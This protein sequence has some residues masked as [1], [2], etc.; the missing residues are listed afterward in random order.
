[1]TMPPFRAEQVGSLLRPAELREARAAAKAGA[2]SRRRAPSGGGPLDPRRRGQAGVARPSRRHRRRIPAR[3]LA[4]RLSPPARGRGPGAG[5]GPEVPG[6]GRAAD[7]G[8][9]RRDSLRG[10]D[11]GGA[12]PLPGVGDDGR[13]QAHHPGARHAAPARRARRDLARALSGPGAVLERRRPRVPRGDRAP[14][15]GGMRVSAARRRRASPTSA[16]PRCATGSGPAATIPRRCPGPMRT[17]STARSPAARPAW[18]WPCT[19]AAATSAARGWPRCPTRKPS[20]RPCSR[21]TSTPIFM[22]WDSER[23]GGFAPLRRLPRGKTGCARPRHHQVGR[24]RVEGVAEAAHRRSGAVRAAGAPG[25]VTAVR[26]REHPPR[27]H[28][29]RGRAVAQARARG[30]G[31]ARGLG[32]RL[33]GSRGKGKQ[34]GDREQA[35]LRAPASRPG[36]DHGRPRSSIWASAGSVRTALDRGC[37]DIMRPQVAVRSAM[38]RPR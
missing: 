8:G 12:L 35:E 14:R 4:P 28:A 27:Q 10:A 34:R 38:R 3:F 9:R 26:L 16:I 33:S 5:H 7:A 17:R 29:H 37:S 13:A 2:I 32:R 30:R 25:P 6:R 18:R 15:C 1:M 31:R 19:P 23:A 21:P 36:R 20:W 11:H 24:A 22:E